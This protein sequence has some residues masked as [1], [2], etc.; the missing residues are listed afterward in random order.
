M[1]S[2]AAYPNSSAVMSSI[3]QQSWTIVLAVRVAC[4]PT[5]TLTQFAAAKSF[6]PIP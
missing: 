6:V 4:I 3:L 2:S 5:N 1:R